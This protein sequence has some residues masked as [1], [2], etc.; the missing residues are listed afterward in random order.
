MATLVF[1]QDE[2]HIEEKNMLTS[3][4]PAFIMV[5]LSTV[6][7]PTIESH[8]PLAGIEGNDTDISLVKMPPIMR[9]R[10]RL[11]GTGLTVIGLPK[12]KGKTQ[13]EI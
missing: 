10:G 1:L 12:K 3:T 4:N 9:K 13:I 11:K 2:A 8:T 5:N 6:Q 7:P